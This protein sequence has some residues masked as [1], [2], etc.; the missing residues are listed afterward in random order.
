[1]HTRVLRLIAPWRTS[2]PASGIYLLI[3][4]WP[5]TALVLFFD[6]LYVRDIGVQGQ[7]FSNLMAPLYLVVLLPNLYPEQRLMA[8][9]F[10]P[11]ATIGEFVFS[12]LFQL[13]TYADGT[14]PFY[15]PFGHAILFGTG[16]VFCNLSW[17]TRYMPQ[18]RWV[19]LAFHAA[20]LSGVIIGMGDTLSAFFTLP[21]SYIFYRSRLRLFY[22]V[23]GVLVLFVEV[24]GTR[25]G[26]WYWDPEP[27]YGL[28]HAVNPPVAAFCCY[29]VA[30]ILVIRITRRLL[31]TLSS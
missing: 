1:M 23:M 9:V 27:V 2:Q 7:L 12:L 14:V 6:S 19:L 30:D 28:L 5:L 20:L 24:V 17:T 10:L 22:L 25:F 11:V 26:C 8:L 3:L 15:V 18:I 31:K 29:V 13:Y 16:L 4:F 21:L